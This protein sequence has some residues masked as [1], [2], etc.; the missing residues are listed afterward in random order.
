MPVIRWNE[1]LE[2]VSDSRSA[3]GRR[4]PLPDNGDPP[5]GAGPATG[6]RLRHVSGTLA[7]QGV[8]WDRSESFLTG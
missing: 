4:H 3:S 7:I 6:G 8:P 5:P 1:G 2:R